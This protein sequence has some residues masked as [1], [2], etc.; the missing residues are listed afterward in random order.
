ML[1]SALILCLA[2]PVSAQRMSECTDPQTREECLRKASLANLAGLCGTNGMPNMVGCALQA[3]CARNA[4]HYCHPMSLLADVCL[5]DP[6]MIGMMGCSEYN[7]T[8]IASPNPPKECSE[9]G[10]L[11]YVLGTDRTTQNLLEMCRQMS[12]AACS[13]CTSEMACA[14]PLLTISTVCKDHTM[15]QCADWIA[16]CT[17]SGVAEEP[18]GLSFCPSISGALPLMQMYF[19]VGIRDF[20][21]FKGW[22]PQT[23]GQYCLSLLFCLVLGIIVIWLKAFRAQWE[24]EHTREYPLPRHGSHLQEGYRMEHPSTRP[25]PCPICRA[26]AA[27]TC[28]ERLLAP[29]EKDPDGCGRCD[30]ADA[31]GRRAAPPRGSVRSQW[32]RRWAPSG[33]MSAFP[34]RENAVR[35]ALVLVTALLDYSLMLVVMTFNL[36]LFLAGCL[37]L[38]AGTFLFGHRMARNRPATGGACCDD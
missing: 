3:A 29:V 28:A 23:G 34:W 37:G 4:E 27:C 1:A 33:R 19:H 10:P 14:N 31:G 13:Q 26:T 24:E 32:W 11:P 7:R 15:V 30:G 6:G 16:M 38:A 18:P 9:H 22:V 5:R 35:A 20:V 25:Q 8:C 17:A 2:L 12:M 36:G 21:L